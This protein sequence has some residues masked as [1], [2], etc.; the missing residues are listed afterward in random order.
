MVMCVCALLAGYSCEALWQWKAIMFRI[1]LRWQQ[2]LQLAYSAGK[3]PGVV[4]RAPKTPEFAD[5]RLS[6]RAWKIDP[7]FEAP[8]SPTSLFSWA[9]SAQQVA[10]IGGGGCK[11]G[12][13]S[14]SSVA[15]KKKVYTTTAETRLFP[16]SGSEASRVYTLLSGPMVYAPFPF[17]PMKMAYTIVFFA[18]WPRGRATDRERR[19]DMVSFPL[20]LGIL[21]SGC[22][23]ALF[24]TSLFS[25]CLECRM[26]TR[27][28]NQIWPRI[29]HVVIFSHFK[30]S[31]ANSNQRQPCLASFSQS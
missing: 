29:S 19:G 5:P 6:Q 7:K 27:L 23:L 9:T 17:F 30:P 21:P 12:W 28:I 16:F 2:L 13:A 8:S 22:R 1:V 26:A 10:C 24:L 15:R 11:F 3:S 14:S 25:F 20:V 31:L 4:Q 18:L